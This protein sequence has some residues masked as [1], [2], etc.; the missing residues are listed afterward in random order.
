MEK[1]FKRILPLAISLLLVCG[2]LF[3]IHATDCECEK[4]CPMCDGD[5][6]IHIHSSP[7]STEYYAICKSC[8]YE[9]NGYTSSIIPQ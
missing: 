1:R 4:F 3:A 6:V 7:N 2:G 5:N 9:W 8:D